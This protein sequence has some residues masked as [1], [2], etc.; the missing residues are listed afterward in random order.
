MSVVFCDWLGVSVPE[1]HGSVLA[2]ELGGFLLEQGASEV[3]QGLYRFPD[4][5]TVKVGRAHAVWAVGVSG[6]ALA[7][8][9][10]EGAFDGLLG[11]LSA[12][13]HQVT[14]LDAS[15]D[16]PEDA[17][18]RLW[19]LYQKAL[20]GRV[21]LGRKAVGARSVVHHLRPALYA[22]GVQTGSLYLGR[23]GDA[24]MLCVYDK[25]N[26]RLDKG[27]LDLG[28]C[29]RYEL[30]LDGRRSGVTLRDVQEPG[31]VFWAVMGGQILERPS[32]VPEWESWA[33]GFTM[34][35]YEA[36]EPSERLRRACE[37][38]EALGGLCQL[39]LPLGVPEGL[40]ALQSH[41]GAR[42]RLVAATSAFQSGAMAA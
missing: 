41:V 8:L 1:L 28:P 40:A 23:R 17:S 27:E 11:L 42:Y 21:R 20:K 10:S 6:K 38:S 30:R 5:G 19:D 15:L 9:R 35:R 25:R 16:L 4:G 24:R 32:G 12:Y 7:L 26:E 36:P 33:E 34:P 2:R 29:T 18:P 14:R 37:R 31:P 22:E 13:P 3:Q 39:A